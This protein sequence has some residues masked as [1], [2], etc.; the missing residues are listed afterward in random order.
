MVV[1]MTGSRDG[2]SSKQKTLCKE[3]L[4]TLKAAEFHHG[5]CV[6]A[7]AKT[8]KIARE[9]G[10]WI[11][12]HPPEKNELRA[13]CEGDESRKPKGYLARNR[14]I[15]HDSEVMLGFPKQEQQQSK[16]GTWYTIKYAKKQGKKLY[17]IYPSG[18]VEEIN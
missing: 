16:G 6:G 5:D 18:N 7:D 4:E 15:V 8:H 3:F 17:I 9:L 1:G 13:F 14:D 10:I 2:L 12:I 11:V